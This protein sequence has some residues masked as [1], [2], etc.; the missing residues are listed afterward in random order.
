MQLRNELGIDCM[1]V[2]SFNKFKKLVNFNID[3]RIDCKSW[4]NESHIKPALTPT[5]TLKANFVN[6]FSE[7]D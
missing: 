1:I 7:V 3:T 4:M 2:D 6:D 5:L